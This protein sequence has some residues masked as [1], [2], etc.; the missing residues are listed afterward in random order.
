MNDVRAGMQR[1]VPKFKFRGA[2]DTYDDGMVEVVLNPDILS[3]GGG[4]KDGDQRRK[5][6]RHVPRSGHESLSTSPWE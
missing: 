1:A 2:A 6:E 3:E 5:R 4:R